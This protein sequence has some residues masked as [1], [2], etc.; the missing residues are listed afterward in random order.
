MHD[1][2]AQSVRGGDED[3]LV[4][5]RLGVEREHDAGR[6]QVAAHHP[7]NARGKRDLRIGEAFVHAVGNRA[8]V[9]EGREHL[10]YRMKYVIQTIDIEECFLL[11][12]ERSIRQV[13]RRGR[14]PHGE[15]GVG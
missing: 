3:H 11:A 13:L 1:R 6:A 8:I 9:I 15:C 12:G 4:E 2:F 14:G 7:L 5:A 10:S